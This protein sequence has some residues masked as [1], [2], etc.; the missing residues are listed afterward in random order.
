[1]TKNNVTGSIIHANNE[2]DENE[3]KEEVNTK[4]LSILKYVENRWSSFHD[5]LLRIVEL[6][7]PLPFHASKKEIFC[8]YFAYFIAYA[9]EN[10]YLKKNPIFYPIKKRNLSEKTLCY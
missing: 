1:M 7:E 6:S 3:K 8:N 4:V 5:A 2:E 9:H 10:V